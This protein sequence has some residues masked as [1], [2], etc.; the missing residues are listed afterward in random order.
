MTILIRNEG[1]GMKI[2]TLAGIALAAMCA[3]QVRAADF[4]GGG[5]YAVVNNWSGFYVGGT[6]G[7]IDANATVS[8]NVPVFGSFSV[9]GSGSQFGV[10]ALAG[11]NWQNGNQVYGIETDIAL[12][13]GFDYFGTLRARY[14]I[15]NGNWLFYGTAGLSFASSGGSASG[16]GFSFNGYNNIGFVVGGGAETKI[17]DHLTAGIEGLYYGLMDDTQ[18]VF[19][20]TIT[21]RVDAFAVRARVTYQLNGG[22]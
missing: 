2:K 1:S 15:L 10:G 18:N 7:F 22:F 12:P 4:G 20:S 5:S 19:G 17:N 14:G 16:F 21:T 3:A 8:A 9:S 13:T 6:L 11:Y